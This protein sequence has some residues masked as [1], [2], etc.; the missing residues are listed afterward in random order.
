MKIAVCAH[1]LTETA[2]RVKFM[3]DTILC[4]SHRCQSVSITTVGKDSANGLAT[5][6]PQ[7]TRDLI[8]DF[9]ENHA[10]D[11]YESCE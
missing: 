11:N 6:A 7:L 5:W 1:M 3:H 2:C 4:V 8:H 10:P 9:I